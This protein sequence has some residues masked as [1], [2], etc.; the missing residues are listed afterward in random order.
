[1]TYIAQVLKR[2]RTLRVLNLA[3]NRVEVSGFV[4]IAEA[5]VR[6]TSPVVPNGKVNK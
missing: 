3:D 1:M 6:M 4:A 2:N 5:L